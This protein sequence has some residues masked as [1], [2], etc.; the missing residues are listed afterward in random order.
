[1]SGAGPNFERQRS[2]SP[3]PSGLSG[4]DP[5]KIIDGKRIAA[6]VLKDVRSAAHELQS[7]YGVSPCIAVIEVGEHHYGQ[8]LHHLGTLGQTEV[9]RMKH[10]NYAELKAKMAERHGF[11]AQLLRFSESVTQARMQKIIADLMKDDDVHGILIELP[12]PPHLNENVLLQCIG[13][14]KDVDGL[15]FA[16]LGRMMVGG[17]F[18]NMEPTSRPSVSMG[19]LELL[20]RSHVPLQGKQAVVVGRSATVGAPVAQ[21]LT[22]FDCTVTVCHSQT[23]NLKE[24][25]GRADVLVSCA[26]RPEL[27]PGSWIK[28]GAVVIDVGMNSVSDGGGGQMVVGDVS[29]AE[30]AKRASKITPV[31]GGVGH[32]SFAILLRNA[33]NLARQAIKLT[34]IGIGPSGSE[35]FRCSDTL[36]FPDIGLKVPRILLPRKDL[37]LTKWC[38]VA[39]DQYTS[40]PAYWKDVQTLVGDSPS[41]L[42]LIFPEVYLGDKKTNQQIIQ[43]IKDKMFA[44]DRDR[45]LVPQHPGFVLLD[46][47]T[48]IVE[49]RKGLIV[50][51]DLELYSYEKGTQSLIRPTEKTIPDR[52]PPRI[53]IREQ[54]PLELPHILV[55]IDDPEMTVI[56]PLFDQKD[57]F[58]K[59]YD[60]ELMKNSGHSKG[61]HIARSDAVDGVAKALR[62]LAS[63][64]RFQ[65][66]YGARPD[67]GTILFPVGDGNHS[68][69][70][71][72]WCWEDLKRK[73]ADKETHPARYALVELINVHDP[74]MNFEPIQR[75]VFKIDVKKALAD[76]KDNL[77]KSGCGPVRILEGATLTSAPQNPGHHHIEFR[78]KHGCGV[79]VVESPSLVLEVATLQSW[80]DPYLA[81]HPGSEVD[82][83]HGEEVITEQTSAA[84][85][86]LAFLLPIMDKND[87]VKTVVKEGV[88]PRKTFSMGAADEKRFYFECQ[89][90]VPDMT[91]YKAPFFRR[92]NVT[93]GLGK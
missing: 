91:F 77:E 25:V 87:L 4:V 16:N 22:A 58:E 3:R 47:K 21:L 70:T 8:L 30:A 63:P 59:L 11:R 81:S 38:V 35:T 34:K 65:E 45:I 78:H 71:A 85:T 86:T 79:F 32:M 84:D 54:S 53:A 93:G 90:I 51:L 28:E 62:G 43:G 75:L 46:R 36:L 7:K 26:G 24:H 37:D 56:E 23:V 49:S 39:C 60:F 69:A 29:F 83:V 41:T 89:R 6:E 80:L 40:Q 76:M 64:T 14:A 88:L 66:R 17:G 1:M 72:K 2:R 33:L 42:N 19:V 61:W 9:Q 18:N 31:P 12:L 52:L 15:S 57:S 55:L 44:F 50:A 74:G 92:G 10:A 48:P 68:L 5:A 82:Y 13:P 73:G 67:Q 27:I 20:H